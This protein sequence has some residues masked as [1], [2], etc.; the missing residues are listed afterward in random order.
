MMKRA[1]AVVLVGLVAACSDGGGGGGDGGG[2]GH[3]LRVHLFVDTEFEGLSLDRGLG[4]PCTPYADTA[5][6]VIRDAGGEIIGTE[7]GSIGE[8][9]LVN[10]D[11]G[12]DTGVDCDV[13]TI[14]V[15]DVPDSDYYEVEIEGVPGSV[16]ASADELAANDWTLEVVADP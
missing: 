2:G 12:P 14:S 1:V 4:D 6:V 15:A 3:T 16:T 11:G 9:T 10:V 7:T 8:G 13:G 5:R